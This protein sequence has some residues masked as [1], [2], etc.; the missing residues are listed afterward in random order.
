ME[1]MWVR[2]SLSAISVVPDSDG[3][4]STP[5]ESCEGS[6]IL[7]LSSGL[8]STDVMVSSEV[9]GTSG[10]DGLDGAAMTVSGGVETSG[11]TEGVVPSSFGSVMGASEAV[12][13]GVG[14]LDAA[15]ASVIG[16]SEA[17]APDEGSMV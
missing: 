13:S 14:T 8:V 9:A 1:S 12:V 3:V 16:V 5:E 2:E 17:V 11:L 15:G 6:S 4:S 7:V 10:G